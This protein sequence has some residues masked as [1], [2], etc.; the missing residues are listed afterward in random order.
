MRYAGI[1]I[2]RILLPQPVFL[3]ADLHAER[4]GKYVDEFRAIV[5]VSAKAPRCGSREFSIESV[6]F[7]VPGLEV[8]AFEAVDNLLLHNPQVMQYK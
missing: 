8:E 6:V 5:L 2:D 4:A 3:L 1:K 7:S